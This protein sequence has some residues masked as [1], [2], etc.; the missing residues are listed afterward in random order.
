MFSTVYTGA[1][2]G[3]SAYIVS[4]EVDVSNGLPGFNMVGSLS[5]E[6][7]EARERVCVTLKNLG[8]DI[9]PMRITVNLAPAD[10]RK[11]G[12]AFDLP[13]AIGLLC[14]LD[15]IPKAI[16]DD[17]LFIGELGLN[18]EIKKA[19]SILQDFIEDSSKGKKKR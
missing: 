3:V 8:I 12:T 7:R 18:G 2:N 11:E 16:T 19:K 17:T 10:Q 13:I 5:G 1:L 9:P 6:V 14:S 4:V 15:I